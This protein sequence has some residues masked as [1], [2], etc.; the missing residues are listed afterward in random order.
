VNP[1]LQAALERLEKRGGW[2]EADLNDF[3]LIEQR[4]EELEATAQR[5]HDAYLKEKARIAELERVVEAARIQAI[6]PG[7]ADDLRDALAALDGKEEG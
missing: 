7:L 3:A 6:L 1:D 5:F 4:L 2:D